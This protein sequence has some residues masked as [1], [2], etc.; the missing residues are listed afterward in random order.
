MKNDMQPRCPK[1]YIN[2]RSEWQQS[3]QPYVKADFKALEQEF[4]GAVI[5]TKEK[6]MIQE[7]EDAFGS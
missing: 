5:A 1:A 4:V 7:I 2:T 6:N 3:K